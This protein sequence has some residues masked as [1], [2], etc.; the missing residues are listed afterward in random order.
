MRIRPLGFAHA[1]AFAA[2]GALLAL[3]VA[4]AQQAPFFEIATAEHDPSGRVVASLAVPPDV[5]LEAG[6][7]TAL[8][9]DVPHAVAEVTK[10]DPEPLTVVVAIDVSGSMAGEPLAS[11]QQ[12]AIDLIDRLSASDR[13]AVLAFAAAPR[14]VSD[15]TTNRAASESALRGLTAGGSTALYGAVN[16]AA[17]MLVEAQTEQAVLVLLSDG[18]DS[19]GVSGVTREQSAQAIV[20]SGAAVYAFALG[21]QADAAYLASLADRTG[22]EMS[23]VTGSEALAALFASLGRRLGA[24]I[25]VSV[26]VPAMTIGEHELTLRFRARG[27]VVESSALFEVS[28]A[29]LIVAHVLPPAADAEPGDP[30][31]V[32]LAS[33]IPLTAM[34][35]EAS[36]GGQPLAVS[37]GAAR[38]LVDPWTFD[39]GALEV[40][41]RGLLRGGVATEA[42]V[43]VTIP[44]L[45]PQLTLRRDENGGTS[46]LL[47]SAQVQGSTSALLRVLHDG[48]EVARGD[49]SA[50]LVE[51]PGQGTLIIQ[52]ET[53]QGVLLESESLTFG[54]PEPAPAPPPAPDVSADAGG[55]LLAGPWWQYAAAG[56]ALLLLVLVGLLTVRLLRRRRRAPMAL[57]APRVL[58]RHQRER[59]EGAGVRGMIVVVGPDRDEH[60]VPLRSRPITIGRWAQCDIVL[61]DSAIR[62]VHVRTS[63]IGNG[64]FWVHGLGGSGLRP[65]GA[66]RADERMLVKAGDELALG[67]YTIRFLLADGTAPARAR[68]TPPDFDLAPAAPA[69]MPGV[70]PAPANS[71]AGQEPVAAAEPYAA[72]APPADAPRA[73]A[74]PED[75]PPADT[76]PAETAPT[77]TRDLYTRPQGAPSYPGAPAAGQESEAESPPAQPSPDVRS[78]ADAAG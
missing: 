25:A 59:Q 22:G 44:E 1:L 64:E 26:D 23:A 2:V 78:A 5:T 40:Q 75:T 4:A 20:D 65:A 12:A 66:T 16:T 49:P 74:Q 6:N 55:G 39:P 11:A 72:T 10:R 71:P 77:D 28:N 47:V 7:L 21:S 42:T 76:P 51:L 14:V 13:I 38:I 63:A 60:R 70:P 30:I 37:A 18:D 56:G 58:G 54:V 24:D 15:F 41:V 34:T 31:V 61:D 19:G 69:G 57:Q 62:P 50:L 73:G 67:D 43:S 68:E 52:L 32:Q 35:L 33:L 9:D 8:L 3:G 45:A 48:Q 17:Q 53:A 27:Q 29:G 36:A 46:R